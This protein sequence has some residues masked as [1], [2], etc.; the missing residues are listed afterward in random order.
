[1]ATLVPGPQESVPLEVRLQYLRRRRRAD[2]W[3]ALAVA[4]MVLAICWTVAF[5]FGLLLH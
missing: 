3:R 5:G 2:P 4:A 1:M